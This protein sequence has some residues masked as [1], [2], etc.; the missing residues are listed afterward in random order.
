[1]LAT[2][3]SL[4]LVVERF[5]LER[6]CITPG[7]EAKLAELSL[8]PLT[9]LARHAKGDWGDVTRPLAQVN[10]ASLSRPWSLHSAYQLGDGE[11][12]WIQTTADRSA[13]LLLLPDE[14]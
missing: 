11:Q 12:L 7:A 8:N 10:N 14:A 5:P 2:I 1:M 4:S 13:T 6:L 3:P 9:F